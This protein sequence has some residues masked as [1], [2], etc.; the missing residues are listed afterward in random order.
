[1]KEAVKTMNMRDLLERIRQVMVAAGELLLSQSITVDHHKTKNDLLTQNDLW[2]EDFIIEELKK[3]HP[4]IHIVSEEYHPDNRP[5][6]LTVVIDPIDGT[7]N[8]AASLPLF[9]IQAAVFSENVCRGA[10]IYFPKNRDLLTAELGKG[11]YFN[12]RR[13][14]VDPATP[15]SDGMLIIS[16]Y[17]DNI[18]IPFNRQFALVKALQKSFLKTRHFGAAC[19]DFSMLAN[20]NALAYITYYHKLWDIAPGLLIAAEAGC[21]FGA[22]DRERYEYGRPG[23]VAANS[24]ETLR[25]ILDT[26]ARLSAAEER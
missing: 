1:M 12:G 25:L 7:C 22:L 2:I 4:Q 13:L 8:Y 14:Q 9:G 15:A 3:T 11:A 6:G 24:P 5:D 26:Y 23:L 17:Y 10:V 16:D 19:V 18:D 21:V 20:K